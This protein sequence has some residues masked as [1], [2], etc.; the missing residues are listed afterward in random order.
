MVQKFGDEYFDLKGIKK[1]GE[2][3]KSHEKELLK[4]YPS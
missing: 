4:L 2:R 1:S 3:R